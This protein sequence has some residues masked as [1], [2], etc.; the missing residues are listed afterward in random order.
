M[1]MPLMCHGNH[2]INIYLGLG[3]TRRLALTPV[4]IPNRYKD[5]R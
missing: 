3:E 5:I 1:E 4:T 2:D